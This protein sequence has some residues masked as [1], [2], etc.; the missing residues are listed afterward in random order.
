MTSRCYTFATTGF[1]LPSRPV[2]NPDPFPLLSTPLP[3][4]CAVLH[5]DLLSRTDLNSQ[6]F[7]SISSCS[8]V[9]AMRPLL[10]AI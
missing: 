4:S 6:L 7:A 9:G 5:K 10:G 3:E 8:K 1:L 2:P